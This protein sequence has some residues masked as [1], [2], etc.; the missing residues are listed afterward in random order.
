MRTCPWGHQTLVYLLSQSFKIKTSNKKKNHEWSISVSG[1]FC[2]TLI[3]PECPL[4]A[5]FVLF[6]TGSVVQKLQNIDKEYVLVLGK[7]K[8]IQ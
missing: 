1:Y 3:S 7:H 6:I 4:E 2:L 5:V 8:C